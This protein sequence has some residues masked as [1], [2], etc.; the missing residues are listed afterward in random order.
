MNKFGQKAEFNGIMMGMS[1]MIMSRDEF[2]NILADYKETDWREMIY[3]MAVEKKSLNQAMDEINCKE[4][5]TKVNFDFVYARQKLYESTFCELELILKEKNILT[6][7]DIKRL[8]KV[9]I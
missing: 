2:F 3:K 4:G 8:D 9:K 1:S 5:D 7:E 6:D